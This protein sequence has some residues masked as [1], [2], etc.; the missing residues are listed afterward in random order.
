MTTKRRSVV[1]RFAPAL[2]VATFLIVAALGS[3]AANLSFFGKVANNNV[4]PEKGAPAQRAPVSRYSALMNSLN[5]L[6]ATVQTDKSDY[7]PGQY[8]VVTGS[9]WWANETVR[10]TFS[11][12]H[13]H[14]DHIIDTVADANGNILNSDFLVDTSQIGNTITLTATGLSSLQTAT[15]TFTDNITVDFKQS[16]NNETNGTITGLG[17]I[18]WIGSIVQSSNSRYF[19]GMSNMQRTI[20]IDVP[21]VTADQHRLTIQHQFTKGGIHAYDF[22]TS[23]LQAVTD[24]S[25]ALGVAI[26]LHPCGEDIGPPGSLGT[27]CATLRGSD[28]ATVGPGIS[29]CP[30]GPSNCAVD[31]V[32][33][34]DPYISKDGS[35]ASKIAAYEAGHGN[36]TVRIY[37]NAPITGASISVCHDVAASADTGDSF[38]GYVLTWTSTSTQIMVEMAGHLAVTGDDNTGFNWGPGLGSSQINGGPYHFKLGQLGGPLDAGSTGCPQLLDNSEV[39]SLGSQDNQIK[40]ADI[41]IPPPPCGITGP[42]TACAGATPLN[43]SAN[44][45]TGLTYVWSFVGSANGAT[46]CSGTTASTV[47][48]TAGTGNFTLQVAVTSAGGTTTCTKAVTVSNPIASSTKTDVTCNGGSDGSMTVTITGGTGPFTCSLDGGAFAPCVSGAVFVGLAAGLHTVSV[49][50]SLSCPTSTSQTIG[51]P[52]ALTLSLSK[53]DVSC[54]GG[55]DGSVTA[56]FGGGTG[57]YTASLDGGAPAAATSP[58]TFTGLAAGSHTVLIT[59]AHGCTK[60]DSITVGQPTAVALVLTPTNISCNGANDGTI[61]VS[62]SGGTTPYQCSLDGSAFGA[63]PLAYTGVGPGL[64]TVV[65]RDAHSCT[66]TKQVTITQPDVLTVSLGDIVCGTGSTI[67]ATAVGGSGGYTYVW[68][69]LGGSFNPAPGPTDATVTYNTQSGAV[70]IKVTVTDVNGCTATDT[71]EA[72]CTVHNLFCTLTQGAYG[73]AKGKTYLGDQLVNRVQLL[74]ALLNTDLTLGVVGEKSLTIP[75]GSSAAASAACIIK[76][77]PGGT[78]AKELYGNATPPVVDRTLDTTTC[79]TDPQ[80]ATQFSN[81]RWQNV[82]LTQTLTLALN[83]R[84]DAHGDAGLADFELCRYMAARKAVISIDENGHVTYEDTAPNCPENI[85]AVGI[86]EA[87]IAELG[88]GATVQDLLDLANRALAGLPTDS[89]LDEIG[90]AVGS[91]NELFDGCRFLIYCSDTTPFVFPPECPVVSAPAVNG[92]QVDS[93][94]QAATPAILPDV[95]RSGA[96]R[97]SMVRE[98]FLSNIVRTDNYASG[99]S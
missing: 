82:L 98:A 99:S 54:N 91:I 34:D 16:A 80:A 53:T 26:Q 67:T 83:I 23:Y 18:H 29:T 70:S 13:E 81:G 78:S 37:G 90:S 14:G 75:G 5:P 8:V 9:G 6:T 1:V 40:G 38:A 97:S 45:G 87:V 46:F 47:C 68:E 93:S 4:A 65:A 42:A 64:H 10:L 49:L 94:A 50:D 76:R 86:P 66:D 59:D 39:T 44:T 96:F 77:L 3:S 79:D 61:G 19:E 62:V 27:T 12:G 60:S 52:P 15:T 84:F 71:A 56:T 36:R 95:F 21:D 41:L 48:V 85:T 72:D 88:D 63:C 28:T 58:K 11:D 24:D 35:T 55:S 89:T 74:T 69:I 2:I 73:N 43:Y 32:V 30:G 20:L 31:V 22:L 17:N 25:A 7:Q 57:P 92:S 33:P 51:Q